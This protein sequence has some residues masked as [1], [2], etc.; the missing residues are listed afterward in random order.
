MAGVDPATRERTAGGS[1]ALLVAGEL[2]IAGIAPILS[3]QAVPILGA[4]GGT[5][6]RYRS[7]G[8]ESG[9]SCQNGE[10]YV[11]AHENLRDCFRRQLRKSALMPAAATAP[12]RE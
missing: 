1:H 11:T 6:G 7:D 9:K 3:L 10:G 12:V 4:F 5:G 2:A 8:G